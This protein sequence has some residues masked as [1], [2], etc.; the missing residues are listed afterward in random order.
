MVLQFSSKLSLRQDELAQEFTANMILLVVTTICVSSISVICA[1]TVAIDSRVSLIVC[2]DNVSDSHRAKLAM[3]LRKITGW[4]T[5][6]FDDLGALNIGNSSPIGG[7]KTARDLIEKAAFG[8]RAIILEEANKREDVAFS[9]VIPGRLKNEVNQQPIYVVLIDFF[10]F[11][12]LSGD[13]AALEAFN[14]GWALL[15]EL[16]HVVNSSVD[17]EEL[18]DLGECEAHINQ[19][20]M[21][22]HL[23]ERMLY[24]FTPFPG[25]H[26][27]DFKTEYVRLP[28]EFSTKV[29]TRKRYWVVCDASSI[30]LQV[31]QKTRPTAR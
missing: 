14:E 27:V 7:S 10:D 29:G 5:L 20:R 9:R 8:S 6:R 17:P 1:P 16:D 3:T 25:T 4:E 18:E 2:K 13:Y 21:E 15:H 12:K 23:P 19:M 28:F 31:K 11:E 30:G 22:C 24:F 26:N